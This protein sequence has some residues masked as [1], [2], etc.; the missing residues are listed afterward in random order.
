MEFESGHKNGSRII[1]NVQEEQ[2]KEPENSRKESTFEAGSR[3]GNAQGTSECHHDFKGSPHK[4]EETEKPFNQIKGEKKEYITEHS[5][6]KGVY[7]IIDEDE[8]PREQGE[9]PNVTKLKRVLESR[10]KSYKLLT[11]KGYYLPSFSSKMIC[12]QYF[13]DIIQGTTWCPRIDEVRFCPVVYV[14]LKTQI[15]QAIIV[16]KPES[17]LQWYESA[18]KRWLLIVLATL[19]PAHHFFR[20]LAPA[21]STEVF[22]KEMDYFKL[23]PEKLSRFN[24]TG[25]TLIIPCQEDLVK[26]MIK[27]ELKQ[28]KWRRKK[29]HACEKQVEHL[30]GEPSQI[31]NEISEEGEPLMD[32]EKGKQKKK[33]KKEKIKEEAEDDE[34]E[35][36]GEM[37]EEEEEDE[38][39]P[40]PLDE[41]T[42]EEAEEEIGEEEIWIEEENEESE[43]MSFE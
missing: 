18:D 3:C 2:N 22:E 36:A 29:L 38:V 10:W 21:K 30:K 1:Q 35:R 13:I 32:E 43:E 20:I 15:E 41:E 17:N 28:G 39:K 8:D 14:P 33:I 9:H 7:Y 5:D 34:I 37:E 6:E 25:K 12:T 4:I 23:G 24:R 31:G 42:D 27:R 40:I 16:L 26:R 11:Y 19:A